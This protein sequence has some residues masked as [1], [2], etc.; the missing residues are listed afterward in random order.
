[1]NIETATPTPASNAASAA[2][3][4]VP[5]G[6][7]VGEAS[8]AVPATRTNVRS[9]SIST[10]LF[11]L[12]ALMP[13]NTR[14]SLD[15]AWLGACYRLHYGVED[16]EYEFTGDGWSVRRRNPARPLADVLKQLGIPNIVTWSAWMVLTRH[17]QESTPLTFEY[18]AR[19]TV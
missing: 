17:A 7:Y 5:P 2:I 3:G 12:I 14:H 19:P 15:M 16:I 4:N 6:W 13:A 18:L 10:V 1:M 8:G 11:E 9:R